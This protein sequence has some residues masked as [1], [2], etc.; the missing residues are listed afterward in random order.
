[1][2]HAGKLDVVDEQRPAGQQLAVFIAR[3][4]GAEIPRRQGVSG[5]IPVAV[6]SLLNP[7]PRDQTLG[8][9]RE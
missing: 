9:S 6:A 8:A 3:D 7:G 5:L 1:M 4:R 2:Q